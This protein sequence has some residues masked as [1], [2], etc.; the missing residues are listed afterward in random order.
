MVGIRILPGISGWISWNIEQN[1]GSMYYNVY[2]MVS[3]EAQMQV[4]IHNMC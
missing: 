3:W 2:G 4:N 1:G